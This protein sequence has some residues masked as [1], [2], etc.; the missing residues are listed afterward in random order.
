M[1]RY[2]YDWEIRY[3][4]YIA[5][6]HIMYN[7]YH[8]IFTEP[9][10]TISMRSFNKSLEYITLIF[11]TFI[12]KAIEAYTSISENNLGNGPGMCEA[13]YQETVLSYKLLKQLT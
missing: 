11:I 3:A 1:S 12:A 13:L 4:L 8:Y 9:N 5:Y 7:V 2:E 6:T 10:E